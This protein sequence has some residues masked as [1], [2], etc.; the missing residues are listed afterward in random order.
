VGIVGR[1]VRILIL[2]FVIVAGALTG[3]VGV[4]TFRSL[5]QTDG[6]I[7]VDGLNSSVTVLRDETGIVRIL[8]EDPHDLFLAQGYIHAQERLWQMEVWRHISAGRLSEL[9]GKSTLD[10]DRFIRTLGWRQAAQRDLDAMSKA[11][12]AAVDAYTDGVNAFIESHGQSNLGL[13][14]VAT[15]IRSGTGGVGGYAVEPWTALDSVAW[16]KVQSWQLGGN[17]Q[18]EV[19]RMLADEKLGDRALTDDLFPAYRSDMPVITPSAA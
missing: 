7:E 14:F 2:V 8:G 10:Q 1:L 6:A 13:A 4:V 19:F 16:Q 15:A 17:F 3:I 9:F 18:T 11:T 12:R 5:P